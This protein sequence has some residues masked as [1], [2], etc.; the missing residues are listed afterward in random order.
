MLAH[1]ERLRRLDLAAQ[2]GR[3]TRCGDWLA[4]ERGLA[5]PNLALPGAT[6]RAAARCRARAAAGAKL[7]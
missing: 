2:A 5:R 7:N 4:V 1:P 3:P 6:W